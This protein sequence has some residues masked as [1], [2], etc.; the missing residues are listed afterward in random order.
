MSDDAMKVDSVSKGGQK[1]VIKKVN[2][3]NRLAGFVDWWC[4]SCPHLPLSIFRSFSFQLTIPTLWQ[5]DIDVSNV[6]TSSTSSILISSRERETLILSF[7][8]YLPLSHLLLSSSV[9]SSLSVLSA[10]TIWVYLVISVKQMLLLQL[11]MNARKFKW[12][13]SPLLYEVATLT[14]SL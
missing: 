13:S 6:S 5:W 3:V 9:L 7:P 12:N 10:K 1:F 2:R 4:S 11:L 14:A 8:S